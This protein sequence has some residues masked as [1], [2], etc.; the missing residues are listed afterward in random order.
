MRF[1]NKDIVKFVNSV[2]IYCVLIIQTSCNGYESVFY[3]NKHN[4]IRSQVE[5]SEYV[6]IIT[7]DSIM[8]EDRISHISENILYLENNTISIKDIARMY[9]LRPTGLQNVF[10]ISL[11]VGAV[12]I[13]TL[14]IINIIL[15]N[16]PNNGFNCG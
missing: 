12:I 4:N 2:L 16:N 5:E 15:W 6:K 8:I 3:P 11:I 13:T 1:K 10:E 14:I 7:T 9:V